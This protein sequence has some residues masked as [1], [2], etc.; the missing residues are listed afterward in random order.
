MAVEITF[1]LTAV[2]VATGL[3]RTRHSLS[4]Y[5]FFY[6]F[7]FFFLVFAPYMQYTANKVPWPIMQDSTFFQVNIVLL[8]CFIL[9]DVVYYTSFNEKYNTVSLPSADYKLPN[10]G[11]ILL[12]AINLLLGI[13]F[14]YKANFSLPNLL[15][16]GGSAETEAMEISQSAGLI[17]GI[18]RIMF[19]LT[20]FVLIV[21]CKNKL[22]KLAGLAMLLFFCAPTAT[23]RYFA[24]TAYYP[25]LVIM[26]PFL[27]KYRYAFTLI[28][29]LS[30]L[31]V[32]PLLNLFRH[33]DSSEE[34]AFFDQFTQLHFDSYAS[35]AF[36]WE[37]DIISSGRQLLGVFLFWFPRSMWEDKPV[38]SGYWIATEHEL[39]EGGFSNVSMNFMGE[40]YINFGMIGIVAFV[41]ILALFSKKMDT[42]FWERYKGDYHN[43]FSLYYLYLLPMSFF[44]LRGDLLSSGAYVCG[45]SVFATVM[46][47]IC[48]K[49]VVVS[50]KK[51][52]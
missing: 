28:M 34:L 51:Q 29:S 33:A 20:A 38:G 47:W 48:R 30:L 3:L 31:V 13:F 24:A 19:S 32:F 50:F 4:F 12:L 16:R 22:I 41:I 21:M 27:L 52:S 5:G 39:F 43:F 42:V 46:I 10:K 40:G 7:A 36:V 35:L 17:V 11:G 15:L 6:I 25:I 26:C 37:N 49:L 18:M 23:A 1:L 44:C 14:L 2:Y 45:I 9:Y 8:M